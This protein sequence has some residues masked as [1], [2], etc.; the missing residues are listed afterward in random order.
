ML[1]NDYLLQNKCRYIRKRAENRPNVANKFNEML[2]TSC[3]NCWRCRDRQSISENAVLIA[4]FDALRSKKQ[5]MSADF[6][7]TLS[8]AG[9]RGALSSS[10]STCQPLTDLDIQ[11]RI[12]LCDH[13]RS[14]APFSIAHNLGSFILKLRL[15]GGRMTF[16][17]LTYL[18]FFSRPCFKEV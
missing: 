5:I 16:R 6:A 15:E 8:R 13:N 7:Q 10:S 1:Q 9:S 12:P 18:P 11:L 3:R 17:Q 14:V 4:M 2:P